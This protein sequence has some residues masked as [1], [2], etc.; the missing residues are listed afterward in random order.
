M[1]NITLSIP[2]DLKQEMDKSKFMN[3][4]EVARAAIR[5]KVA[6]LKI[7]N[8]ITAKSKLTKKDAI[9]IGRKIKKSMHERYKREHSEV[10]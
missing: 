4:S 1:V 7:L 6:Q 5:E 8:S 3:W 9:E 2:K 10:Y